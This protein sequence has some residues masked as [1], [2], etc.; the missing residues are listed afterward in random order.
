MLSYTPQQRFDGDSLLSPA[1]AAAPSPLSETSVPVPENASDTPVGEE[2]QEKTLL[3]LYSDTCIYRLRIY[4]ELCPFP[5]LCPPA[6][7][8]KQ[9]WGHIRSYCGDFTMLDGM[10]PQ[11][12]EEVVF[13]HVLERTQAPSFLMNE[14]HM[15][16]VEDLAEL[17]RY[18][19]ER[20]A[21]WQQEKLAAQ[22]QADMDR[23]SQNGG[24]TLVKVDDAA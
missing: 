20:A 1:C 24:F 18:Q 13:Q 21:R 2:E 10:T 14:Y 6:A 5:S 16:V 22:Q 7:L 4:V 8:L 11:Q 23:P 15:R 17:D 9:F 19:D 3:Q 12:T